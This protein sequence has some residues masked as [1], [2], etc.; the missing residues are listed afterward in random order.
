MKKLTVTEDGKRFVITATGATKQDHW[1]VVD[2]HRTSPIY[3]VFKNGVLAVTVNNK[4]DAEKV[5]AKLQE[6]GFVH[7]AGT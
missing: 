5:T 7:V 4:E 1:A 3:A 6:S 2:A